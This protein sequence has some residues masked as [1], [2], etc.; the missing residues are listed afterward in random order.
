MS[1]ATIANILKQP[2]TIALLAKV[3]QTQWNFNNSQ[4]P[5]HLRSLPQYAFSKISADDR[6]LPRP[7][8][9]GNYVHAYYVS[10]VASGAVVGYAYNRNK[11]KDLFLDCMRNMFQTIDQNG[12]Y[13]P[14]QIE[15]E[16]HLVNK[17]TDGLMQA[18]VVF[19]SYTGATPATAVR[20][21]R[22]T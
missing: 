8:R 21:A 3:H 17:F 6:D 12:W 13:M 4:R 9:D 15:V 22:S 11:N 19:P 14:A 5:Y 1:K 7:M 16:H 2:K 20:N 18:G 10:D